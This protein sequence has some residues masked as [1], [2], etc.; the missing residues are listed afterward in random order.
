MDTRQERETTRLGA[1]RI[2]VGL[3]GP[4]DTRRRFYTM[5][6]LKAWGVRAMGNGFYHFSTGFHKGDN[7]ELVRGREITIFTDAEDPTV[8]IDWE[9]YY[10]ERIDAERMTLAEYLNREEI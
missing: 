1:P 4:S 6:S 3:K 9:N 2:R 10:G 7:G 8:I 5:D